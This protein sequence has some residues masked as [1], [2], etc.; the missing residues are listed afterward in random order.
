MCFYSSDY[1]GLDLHFYVFVIFG[2]ICLDSSWVSGKQALCFIVKVGTCFNSVNETNK[3]NFEILE[4]SK[5]V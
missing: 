4:Q 3:E 5:F 2:N 1:S